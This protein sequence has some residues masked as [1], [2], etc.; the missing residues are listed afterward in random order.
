MLEY[1]KEYEDKLS[2]KEYEYR[3]NDR[4]SLKFD[5]KLQNIR[6]D[7]SSEYKGIKCISYN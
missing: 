5:G 6:H 1:V 7:K 3:I 4:F 2:R